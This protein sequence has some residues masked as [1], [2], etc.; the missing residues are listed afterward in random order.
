MRECHQ[1]SSAHPWALRQSPERGGIDTRIVRAPVGT[2]VS[3]RGLYLFTANRPRTRGH[4]LCTTDGVSLDEE[5]S[6]HPWALPLRGEIQKRQLYPRLHA[7]FW[8]NE[9]NLI[10]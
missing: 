8:D 7:A 5:S 2:P 10:R 6:A 1:E 9:A 3:F 4:S